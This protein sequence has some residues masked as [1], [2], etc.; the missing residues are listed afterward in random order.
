M[1]LGFEKGQ[2]R[3]G[4]FLDIYSAAIAGES[5][6][7][8]T[9]TMLFLIGSALVAQP[10]HVFGIDPHYPHPKSLGFK[11]R[12]LTEAG[13]VQMATFKDDML[14]T[15]SKVEQIIDNRLRQVD[16][17]DTP[18][19]LVL[20]EVAALSRSSIG[21]VVAHTM[22]RISTEGRKCDVYMLAG[23]QTWLSSRTGDSSVV[24]DTLTCAYIHRIKPKQANLL[25]QDKNEVEKV[26]KIK[27][28]G[29]A[30][31]CP[32][33]EDSAICRMPLATETDMRTVADLVQAAPTYPVSLPERQQDLPM[34]Q[35]VQSWRK[36]YGSEQVGSAELFKLARAA[37]V[38]LGEGN[39]HAQKIKLGQMLSDLEES[40]LAEGFTIQSAGTAQR[41]KQW[42]LASGLEN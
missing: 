4:S 5:G 1:I 29:E 11:I 28:A 33:G 26:R 40:P 10:V 27:Q 12:P 37:G 41:A 2:P 19:L 18:V 3:R 39:E 34:F 32:V 23:S 25:L 9:S 8:K 38:M 16:T 14:V 24:R 6:S 15:L 20:D 42:R 35:F 31:F 22:E 17:D 21:K 36:T 30:L 13:L 7:G